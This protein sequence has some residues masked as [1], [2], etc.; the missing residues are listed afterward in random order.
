MQN[1]IET[2]MYQIG[3]LFLLPTLLL[4][5]LLFL[6]AFFV[7]GEF[8]TLAL[9]RRSGG[10]RLLLLHFQQNPQTNDDELD[11]FAHRLIECP[12]ITSRVTPML[13]LVATMIPMGPALK[14]LPEG[15]L[16]GVSDNLVL[17]FS[18]VILSLLTASITY[19]V[20]NVKRRW[21]SEELLQI[22]KLRKGDV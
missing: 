6:Y 11:M 5:S 7:L 21:L 22:A 10:G 13:G 20:V 17:A 4:I 12:R 18:A 2:S 9:R 16:A 14:A 8:I 1:T 19:Y 15:N 3:Q